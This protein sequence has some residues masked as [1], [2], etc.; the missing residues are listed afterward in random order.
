MAKL[1]PVVVLWVVGLFVPVF[2]TAWVP[3]DLDTWRWWIH[4]RIAWQLGG[5]LLMF[6]GLGA[7]LNSSTVK[8][9][10]LGTV[11]GLVLCHNAVLDAMQGPLAA[12][13]V[14]SEI[15]RSSGVRGPTSSARLV[16]RTEQGVEHVLKPGAVQRWANAAAACAEQGLP[17]DSLLA[18]R[19]LDVVL[20]TR[21]GEA[22][23]VRRC[24]LGDKLSCEQ[25]LKV[26]R[27]LIAK[28]GAADGARAVALLGAACDGGRVQA[29]T[30][31]GHQLLLGRGGAV[32]D[33]PKAAASYRHACEGGEADACGVLGDLF[34]LGDGVAPDL[35]VA[36]QLLRRACDGGYTHFCGRLKA[37]ESSS[38]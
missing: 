22:G 24:N 1:L 31:L 5:S 10:A 7:A 36:A 37:L 16:L 18:L 12:E 32:R 3:M 2:M 14:W 19:H 17:V 29:C 11:V 34:T 30:T 27:G 28:H 38:K 15:T 33:P 8:N 6:G 35:T 21:C 26:A 4:G 23:L 13:L 20:F 9:I 25:A